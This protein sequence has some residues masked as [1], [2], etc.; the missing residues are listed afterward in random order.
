MYYILLIIFIIIFY[1]VYELQLKMMLLS[2]IILL[3]GILA[4]NCNWY[5]ISDLLKDGTGIDLYNKFKN[6][7][8]D[9]APTNLFGTKLYLV[10]NNKHIKI[11]LNNSPNLFGVGKLKKNFFKSFMSKNVG[12]SM[13]CPWKKRRYI[14]EMALVTDRL[15]IYAEKYNTDL[16]NQLVYWKN[17]KKIIFNDFFNLGKKMVTLLNM[18]IRE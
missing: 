9:F 12:V 8:S 6:K 7:Y 15:H 14:N 3:R 18:M 10:T 13:G 2:T 1:L 16:R 4:P 11:I 5:K 17:K